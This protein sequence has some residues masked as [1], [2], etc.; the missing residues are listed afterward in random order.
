M[1]REVRLRDSFGTADISV[2][3]LTL[4]YGQAEVGK[5]RL[6]LLMMYQMGS[7]PI[8]RFPMHRW[9]ARA[10]GDADRDATRRLTPSLLVFDYPEAGV[11]PSSQ[12]DFADVMLRAALGP[13]QH[14]VIAETH[15]DLLL[16]RAMRR[17]RET[18]AGNLPD[19]CP[20]VRPSDVSVV[21]VVKREDV[22]VA[23]SIPITDDGELGAP[24][25]G[26]F[27]PERFGELG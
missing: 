23:L 4:V 27:F 21:C 1:Q 18:S 14:T 9:A 5:S 17:I 16:L 22:S 25:P 15:S 13:R 11:H 8:V 7:V 10:V 19:G 24:W 12:L 2:R 26:G 3:P 20:A 6:I